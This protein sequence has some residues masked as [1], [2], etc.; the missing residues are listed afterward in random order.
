[1]EIPQPTL[2]IT[3]FANGSSLATSLCVCS[4]PDQKQP[5]EMAQALSSYDLRI[6]ISFFMC[7]LHSYLEPF[8]IIF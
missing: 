3:H 6:K 5:S 8:E 2:G 1:L 7:A 4:S